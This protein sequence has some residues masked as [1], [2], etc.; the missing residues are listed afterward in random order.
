MKG[1]TKDPVQKAFANPRLKK[2]INA[3]AHLARDLAGHPHSNR[4][5][6]CGCGCTKV[7]L[8][9][10]SSISYVSAFAK[11]VGFLQ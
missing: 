2:H 10:D 7:L 11:K 9:K 6:C 3:V 1:L 5:H 8:A 4:F